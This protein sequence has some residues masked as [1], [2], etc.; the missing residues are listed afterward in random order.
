M[1]KSTVLQTKPEEE[2]SPG[3]NLEWGPHVHLLTLSCATR[4][5]P[6]GRDG[7]EKPSPVM[8]A[9]DMLSARRGYAPKIRL[10]RHEVPFAPN[11][12]VVTL[13]MLL[14]CVTK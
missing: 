10:W 11:F 13:I 4:S 8:D 3:S 6:C 9:P 12:T 1:L 7:R 5:S 2:V 14:R